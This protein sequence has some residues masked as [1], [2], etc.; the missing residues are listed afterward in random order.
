MGAQDVTHPQ[1]VEY[2]EAVGVSPHTLRLD[3]VAA[4]SLAATGTPAETATPA[5]ID[6]WWVALGRRHLTPA[7]R[8]YYLRALRRY[9]SWRRDRTGQADP[10]AHIHALPIPRRLPRP[11]PRHVAWTAL[12]A[13]T[14]DTRVQIALAMLAGLRVHEIAQLRPD[15]VRTDNDGH[16][17]LYVIGKGKRE[18]RVPL[19]PDLVQLL[20]GYTW[21]DTTPNAVTLA[22]G[23]RIRPYTAHQ[24][25]HTFATEIHAATK[26]LIAL[27]RLLGHASVQTTQVYADV[28]LDDLDRAVQAAFSAA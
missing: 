17:Y 2:A 15:H 1:Y 7:T 14:G 11:V 24:L 12:A 18:R 25:R 8:T 5:D 23:R 19:A 13:A 27:Q 4:R 21:P 3:Q 20:A 10:T 9:Y 22:I 16:H 26:D 6:R 28:S